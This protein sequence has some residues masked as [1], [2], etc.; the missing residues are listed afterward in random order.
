MRFRGLPVLFLAY[1]V[2]TALRVW[3]TADSIQGEEAFFAVS[4]IEESAGGRI[5]PFSHFPNS[6]AGFLALQKM[7]LTGFGGAER[8]LRFWPF[9]FNLASLG[10]FGLVARKFLASQAVPFA[11]ALF[12]LS[13]GMGVY[14]GRAYG[15]SVDLSV[16][17]VFLLMAGQ[18]LFSGPAAARSCFCGVF[19]ACMIWFS[20]G[21]VSAAAGLGILLLLLGLMRGRT[22][23][24]HCLAVVLAWG[25]GVFV[26]QTFF[27]GEAGSW[28]GSLRLFGNELVQLAAKPIGYA[29]RFHEKV[30]YVFKNVTG[31]SFPGVTLFL[32]FA[33][34]AVLG[35]RH[36]EKLIL[37]LGIPLFAALAPP[38]SGDFLGAWAFVS[39]VPFLIL[40]LAEGMAAFWRDVFPSNRVL[41]FLLSAFLFLQP[42]VS[43]AAAVSSPW[44]VS[45]LKKIMEY[46]VSRREP[47]DLFYFYDYDRE[48][49]FRYYAG[50]LGIA[51]VDYHKGITAKDD[52]FDHF[53]NLEG[54]RSAGR[55]WIF[56]PR[57]I[58]YE[59]RFDPEQ[60]IGDF[61]GSIGQSVES[62]ATRRGAVYLYDLGHKDF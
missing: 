54:L 1:G 23:F 10:L 31:I 33:G 29:A 22:V 21:A 58:D 55:I 37:I 14:L 11:I 49:G 5:T 20:P 2:F 30:L 41:P 44:T 32:C 38:A 39:F 4:L 47:G 45:G 27:P 62:V 24:G 53:K 7:T 8:A 3:W 59:R 48:P 40:L 34:A 19:G 35:L 13:K 42:A 52:W 28:A 50:L 56:F 6:A 15:P 46:A 26:Y 12:V 57:R 9:L 16:L 60:L 18:L 36:K 25:I 51:E 17:L 61:M 43:A